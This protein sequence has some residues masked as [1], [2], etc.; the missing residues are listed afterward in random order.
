MQCAEWEK[1]DFSA[2]SREILLRACT[3][4]HRYSFRTFVLLSDLHSA[5]LRSFDIRFRPCSDAL[6]PHSDALR[7]HFSNSAMARVAMYNMN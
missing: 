7:A 3:A 2:F 1:S 5:V 6:G 4:M